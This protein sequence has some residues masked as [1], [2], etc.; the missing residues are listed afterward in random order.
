MLSISLNILQGVATVATDGGFVSVGNLST[1]DGVEFV[2]TLSGLVI[3]K[4]YRRGKLSA[5]ILLLMH[6]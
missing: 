3:A 1:N 2:I 4:Y 5:G 6:L